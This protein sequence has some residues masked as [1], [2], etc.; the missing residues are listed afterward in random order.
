MGAE[1][2][3]EA[4][5][6]RVSRI[7]DS[8][9]L[10]YFDATITTAEVDRAS[11]ALAVALRTMHGTGP[12][13]RVALYLQNTPQYVI[14]LLAIWKL[15][16]IA[17]PINP[18]YRG[19]ELQRIVDDAQPVG[20]I[21]SQDLASGITEVVSLD[22]SYVV[23]TDDHQ[24]QSRDDARVLSATTAPLSDLE[25]FDDL[26]S[27]FDGQSPPVVELHHAATAFLTYTSGTTGAPKGAVNTHR[28]FIN[29]VENFRDWVALRPGDVVLAIAPLFHITGL[30]LNAGI[31]LLGDAELVLT[32]R[33]QAD[34]VVDA[35]R[36]HHVTFTIGAITAFNAILNSDHAT[37]ADFA[38]VTSLY[39]GGA[40]IPPA[41]VAAFEDRFGVYVHNV[42]G[43]TETT[44]GGIAVPLGERAPIDPRSGTLAIG[45]AMQNVSVRTVG[46]D[47]EPAG[48]GEEGEL[49]LEA[50]QIVPG[51]WNNPIATESTFIA[52][53]LR[54]GD[55]A[56]IDEAGWIFLVDRLKD[57][58]IASGFKVWPREVEDVLYEHPDV[59]EAAVVGEPDPY[60]GETVIAYVSLI[61]GSTA[62]EEEI[63]AFT[64]E[65]LAAYKYPRRV[66]IVPEIPKTPTGK[67]RRSELR[68]DAS[69]I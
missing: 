4:W 10:R 61:S 59:F 6:S 1:H 23:T 36:E 40:P 29:A 47:G 31:A 2:V 27:L 17:V 38:S 20:Y 15:G 46:P 53:R 18:M 63:V 57:V 55:V 28:N 60:R 58:I 16:A 44:G 43:M 41:T 26:I 65:R 67:I 32:Y 42:W 19:R 39:S 9:A 51:Y 7:P 56:V 21:A 5:N 8:V 37:R 48:E 68:G 64:R 66:H 52:G 14:A 34:V 25:R 13:D 11:D 24:F 49:E 30:S 62:R 33:F 45:R 12:G 54:T 3:L 50:P 22:T 35:I 69:P